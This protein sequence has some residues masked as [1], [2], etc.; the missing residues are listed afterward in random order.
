[1]LDF[2][3]LCKDHGLPV[4]EHGDSHHVTEGW[5]GTHCPKCGGTG[6]QLGFN[7]TSGA[8]TCWRCGQLSARTV[9]S[10]LV[11]GKSLSELFHVYGADRRRAPPGAA[12]DPERCLSIPP[13]VG[14]LQVVHRDY[15]TARGFD[16]RLLSTLWG[17]R[18]VGAGGGDFAWRILIP[19]L[20][21]AHRPVCYVGRTI[22]SS[23]VARYLTWPDYLLAPHET[24]YGE[25]LVRG[26]AVIVVEGPTDVWRVGPGAVATFGVNWS[27]EQLKRISAYRRRFIMFD[28]DPAGA[29]SARR[30]A[31]RLAGLPGSTEVIEGFGGDPGGL[32]MDRVKC[33]RQDLGVQHESEWV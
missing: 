8:F 26:D 23:G 32:D 25:C 18:G 9:L 11:P 2:K 30:L 12:A 1:M 7:M 16:W 28:D 24:L 3:R 4:A 6:Y 13:C 14:D 22:A 17:V 31:G 10:A 21:M 27:R 29:K 5:I 15:L 19:V 33:L 20:D